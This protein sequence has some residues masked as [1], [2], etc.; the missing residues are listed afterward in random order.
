MSLVL[1]WTCVLFLSAS[2]L[3]LIVLPGY[4]GL[5]RIGQQPLIFMNCLPWQGTAQ[6]LFRACSRA[7][8]RAMLPRLVYGNVWVSGRTGRAMGCVWKSSPSA[9]LGYVLHADESSLRWDGDYCP[10]SLSPEI[11]TYGDHRMAMAF[12]PALCCYPEVTLRQP[13]VVAKSFPCFWQE[14]EKICKA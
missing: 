1:K 4:F 13:E 3:R 14:W 5:N 12:A 10:P 11:H 9:R 7:A 8:C 6:S 2:L